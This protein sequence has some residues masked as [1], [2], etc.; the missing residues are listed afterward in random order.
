ME[1]EED[2]WDSPSEEN[3]GNNSDE[4]GPK[5]EENKITHLEQL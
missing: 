3:D 4:E 5:P 2:H 1:V